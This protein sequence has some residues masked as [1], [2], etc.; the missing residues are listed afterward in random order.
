MTDPATDPMDDDD[1]LVA[2]PGIG[3]ELEIDDSSDRTAPGDDDQGGG[4]G[5][6]DPRLAGVDAGGSETGDG[7]WDP[8]V[9]D[10]DGSGFETGSADGGPDYLAD[11]QRVT[12]EFAN[13]RKQTE[14]RNQELVARASARLAEALLPVL[15]ACDAAALQGVEGV[16]PIHAQLLGVLG[17]E[18]LEVIADLDD[19]FDPNRHEA[20]MT[21]PAGPDDDGTVVAEVLRTGYA[22]KGRVFRPAMVKVRG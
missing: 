17:G 18:G 6:S 15:D 10:A 9:F 14:K 12:A 5:G 2:A 4:S 21:E 11:L 3:A 19:P 7:G 1:S 8:D 16:E 22:W 13:F 20:V